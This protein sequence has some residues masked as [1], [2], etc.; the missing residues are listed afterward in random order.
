MNTEPTQNRLTNSLIIALFLTAILT[1]FSIWVLQKDVSFS[2]VEKR[3]LNNFP[4][5]QKQSIPEFTYAF[6][7]Y[8]QDHFGLREWFIN[9]YHREA[10]KRFGVSGVPDVVEGRE[11]WLYLSHD[12]MLDDLQGR[13]DFSDPEKKVFWNHL[14][15]KESWFDEQ[16][17]AYIFLVAP[18]KQSIYPEYLPSHFRL[19]SK[20]SRLDEL[21]SAQPV[22]GGASLLDVRSDLRM[23]KN[24]SRLYNKS[25]SHWNAQGAN[26]AYL[27]IMK[28]NQLL[29]TEVKA[30][31]EFHF[32]QEWKNTPGGDL[33][34]MI[35]KKDSIVEQ[36]P[37]VN[38]GKFTSALKAIEEPL[39]SFLSSS[40]LQ[41]Y[42]TT[43]TNRSLKVLV[44][45]DSFF[46]ILSP[47]IS[48]S[49]GDVLF[50]NRYQNDATSTFF[51]ESKLKELVSLFKPDLVI[52][53]LVERNLP[54]FIPDE[55]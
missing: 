30:Q 36:R 22:H 55:I 35:G 33:A 32:L 2:E 42:Q 51:T 24:N 27:A 13:L 40:Q 7:A 5:I 52:E 25:D 37:V 43:K 14:I 11:G 47:F 28:R 39:T 45:H 31:E 53:E 23:E 17:I 21:L 54:N 9:R 48:E 49:Y 46:G 26:L 29:F 3:E 6:D 41:V 1:P 4:T 34:E 18:N 15:T 10:S 50:V 38:T 19:S 12:S 20:P 44:L 16:N 8:F